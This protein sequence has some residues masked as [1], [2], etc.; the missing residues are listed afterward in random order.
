MD[1]IERIFR[2]APDNGTGSLELLIATALLIVLF[3][4]VVR[5]RG[6]HASSRLSLFKA[7]ENMSKGMSQRQSHRLDAYCKRSDES[8][9]GDDSQE[10]I[11]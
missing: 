2:V 1:F 7:A 3:A 11:F 9:V 4:V 6:M 10:K 8:D 5:W